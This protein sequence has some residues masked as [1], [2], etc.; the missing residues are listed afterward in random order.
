LTKEQA[1]L[2]TYAAV[3]LSL[4][5]WRVFSKT[6][7][8]YSF[9]NL[10]FVS[11]VASVTIVPQLGDT[12]N[13]DKAPIVAIWTLVFL[14]LATLIPVQWRLHLTSQ[15]MTCGGFILSGT[16]LGFDAEWL[17]PSQVLGTI[18]YLSWIC[19]ICDL[20]VYTFE[21]LQQT[22]FESRRQ[23]QVLLHSVA[24]DLKTP[25][26]GLA[27]VLDNLLNQ[28]ENEFLITRSMLKRII[29]GSDRQLSLLDS[30]LEIHNCQVQ[31]IFCR[32]QTLQIER[33]IQAV[34][35]DLQPLLV[36]N[37]GKIVTAEGGQRRHRRFTAV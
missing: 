6:K 1:E 21:N 5:A 15:L 19:L 25:V 18:W 26:L 13:N 29:Q 8:G 3:I 32:C 22:E 16:I 23:L 34:I 35:V 10:R 30:L 17:K 27:M 20:G 33:L 2:F 37:Q 31:G 9:P 14:L 11:F 28:P 7:A 4:L 12:L 36:K 24:H